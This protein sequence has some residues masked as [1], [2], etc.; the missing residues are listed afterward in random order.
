MAAGTFRHL[1]N[2]ITIAR[3][4]LVL[5]IAVFIIEQQFLIAL[6]LFTVAGI[7]DGLDGFLARRYGWESAFG[8]LIDPLADKLLM[9]TTA[10]TLGL[11]GHF[12]LTLMLLMIVKDIA[13]LGGVFSYTALAG[14]PQIHPN[15]LGKL[16]TALQII[17]LVSVLLDL[18]F[19]TTV[20]ETF[21]QA[22]FWTVAI[23]TLM[24]GMLYLWV[25]TARLAEDPRWK[26][27]L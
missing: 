26:E 23:M 25:W 3:L 12:P 8:K 27:T 22:W 24:D 11:L 13:I 1:P 2:A 4:I 15:R 10:L 18:S 17:L 16:T 20:P 21:F 5:P 9:M 19:R 7:S 6:V 14:F